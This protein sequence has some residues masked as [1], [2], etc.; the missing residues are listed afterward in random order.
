MVECKRII[1]GGYGY[2][3]NGEK[4]WLPVGE[5][6]FVTYDHSASGNP[7]LHGYSDTCS[8]KAIWI[9]KQLVEADNI[10]QEE[11]K[12][13]D[14]DELEDDEVAV[15]QVLY[16][17]KGAGLLSGSLSVKKGEMLYILD[18]TFSKDWYYVVN[19]YGE[20]GKYSKLTVTNLI[21]MH[22]CRSNYIY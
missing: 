15:A 17:Y 3:S 12:V 1:E 9:S 16:D 5:R 8:S 6:F 20:E 2:E 21:F 19:I 18:D 10:L 4:V 11:A 22:R 13:S 14:Q 7:L